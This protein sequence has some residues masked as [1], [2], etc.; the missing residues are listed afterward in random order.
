MKDCIEFSKEKTAFPKE[1]CK[2]L[3]DHLIMQDKA[4]KIISLAIYNH[5]KSISQTSN[6][7]NR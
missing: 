4:E 1:I 3:D 5:Y 6:K 7:K 2:T